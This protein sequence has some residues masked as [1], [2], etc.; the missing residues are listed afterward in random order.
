MS[1]VL[2][3]KGF[4]PQNVPVKLASLSSSPLYGMCDFQTM[5]TMEAVPVKVSGFLS[6][7]RF[8]LTFASEL[9]SRG[10]IKRRPERLC[11][12]V[13]GVQTNRELFGPFLLL[14]FLLRSLARFPNS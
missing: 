8:I 3:A 6:S 11:R 14:P 13:A 9:C 1:R 10:W 2:P 5:R 7:Y 4:R 12:H